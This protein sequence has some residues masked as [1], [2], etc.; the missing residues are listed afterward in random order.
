MVLHTYAFTEGR[1][2]DPGICCQVRVGCVPASHYTLRKLRGLSERVRHACDAPGV[3]VYMWVRA[4]TCV[5][6][7]V[8]ARVC[9]RARVF[10]RVS[11][12]M[13]A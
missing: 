4:C 12:C 6:V 11:V 8:C 10:V 3:Y 7:R 9:V 2:G 5:R 1:K 13:C